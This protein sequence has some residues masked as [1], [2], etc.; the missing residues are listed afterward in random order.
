MIVWK[1]IEGLK[2]LKI[3][4]GDRE[5]VNRLLKQSLSIFEVPIIM[6]PKVPS[7]SPLELLVQNQLRV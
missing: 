5:E 2:Y 1:E 3:V 6:L 7:K 4:F